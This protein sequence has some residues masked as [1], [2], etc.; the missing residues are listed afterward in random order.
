MIRELGGEVTWELGCGGTSYDYVLTSLDIDWQL[1]LGF[2]RDRVD[3]LIGPVADLAFEYNPLRQNECQRG[4]PVFYIL[5]L[6]SIIYRS[7]IGAPP[8]SAPS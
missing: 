3:N 4:K 1:S 2:Q 8:G 5:I 7:R 6:K